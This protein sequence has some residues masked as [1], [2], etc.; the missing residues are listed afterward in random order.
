[1]RWVVVLLLLTVGGIMYLQR[2]AIQTPT[3]QS[4]EEQP[5]SSSANATV[6][7]GDTTFFV[8][9]Q[10]ISDNLT[11]IPNFERQLASSLLMDNYE[12]AYGA[13]GGFYTPD[14]KPIGFFVFDGQDVSPPIQN[15]TFSGY[16]TGNGHLSITKNVPSVP[17]NFAIQSGPYMTPQTTLRIRNDSFAR[18]VLVARSGNRWYFLAITEKDNTFSGPY[19]ADVPNILG[20]LPIAIDEALNLDGGSASAFYNKAGVRLGELTPIGSFF[21]GK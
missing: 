21:C 12:C 8:Y 19:L 4:K 16:F 2:P 17:V 18:R 14:N 20:D 7:I 11:L 3:Q 6:S 15:S 5:S 13:N 10:E 9:L 1:M